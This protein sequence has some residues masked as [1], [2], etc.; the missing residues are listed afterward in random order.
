MPRGVRSLNKTVENQITEIDLKIGKLQTRLATLK[1]KRKDLLE[2]KEKAD[3]D[4][5]YK[6]VKE[7]G[8]APGEI[9][10]SWKTTA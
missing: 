2:T 4:A 9:L 10:K 3:F 8:M 7:S 5:L 1:A 6:A